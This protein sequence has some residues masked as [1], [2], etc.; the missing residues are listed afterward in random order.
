M[1]V[2]QFRK[3]QIAVANALKIAQVMPIIG[4]ADM[5]EFYVNICNV[6]SSY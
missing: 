5:I 6:Q 4:L 2:A 3:M 1:N